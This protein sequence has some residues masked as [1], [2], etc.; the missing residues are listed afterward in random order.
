MNVHVINKIFKKQ[1]KNVGYL[2]IP[3]PGAIVIKP[4]FVTDE[5]AK[6]ATMKAFL[7]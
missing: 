7:A 6:L 3:G 5:E 2:K 1:K 4:F